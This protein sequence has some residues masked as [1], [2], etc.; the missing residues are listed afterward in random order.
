[1]FVFVSRLFDGMEESMQTENVELRTI[2]L[3]CANTLLTSLLSLTV[4]PTSVQMS[5]CFMEKIN[6]LYDDLQSC[7]YIGMC[8]I[9]SSRRNT[10]L[11]CIA[12]FDRCSEL[13]N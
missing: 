6:L 13:S 8:S 11:Y 9:V 4:S 1:M 5:D 3:T 7:D 10:F 2:V 12:W